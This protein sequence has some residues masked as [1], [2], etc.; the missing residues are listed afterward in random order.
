M[1][2]KQDLVDKKPPP[3]PPPFDAKHHTLDEISE[4]PQ[5]PNADALKKRRKQNRGT[6]EN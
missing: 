2:F 1:T 3:S 6:F 4:P 5:S